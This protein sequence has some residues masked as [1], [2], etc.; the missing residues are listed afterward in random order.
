MIAESKIAVTTL[1]TTSGR[2]KYDNGKTHKIT[3]AANNTH[4]NAQSQ[5]IAITAGDII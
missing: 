4:D 1:A 3:T 5:K 2:K